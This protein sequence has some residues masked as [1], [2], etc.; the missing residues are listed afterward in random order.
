MKL[1]PTLIEVTE[2]ITERSKT[3][4]KAYMEQMEQAR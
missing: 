1:N 4:R 2:R 3:L